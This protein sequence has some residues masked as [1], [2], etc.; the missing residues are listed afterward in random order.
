MRHNGKGPEG[1]SPPQGRCI[2]RHSAGYA[3]IVLRGTPG[4]ASPK[5]MVFVG[6]AVRSVTHGQA[7]FVREEVAMAQRREAF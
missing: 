7:F 4:R 1:L 2:G 6:L 5:S 3:A